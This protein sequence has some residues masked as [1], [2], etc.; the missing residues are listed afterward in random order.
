MIRAMRPLDAN[1]ARPLTSKSAANEL[2][3]P[4][5]PKTPPENRRLTLPRLI[6]SLLL[7]RRVAQRV[8]LAAEGATAHGIVVAR[9][10]ASGLIWD[11]EHLL[12]GDS[13]YACVELLHWVCHQARDAGARRVFLETPPDGPATDIARRSGFEQC[14]TGTVYELAAGFEIDSKD[15]FPARPR[16]RSDEASLFQLY[17]AVVPAPVRAAEA[18][19]YEEWAAL[20]RGGKLWQP[21]IV[22]HPEDYVW[23][24]GSRAVGWMHIIFG[25]RA[26]YL[27][28]LIHPQSEAFAERMV[29]DA[30]AQLSAK[31]PVLADVRE[32]QGM[33]QVALERVGFQR[34]HDY[35]VWVQQLA[36]RV[37]EPAVQA[38]RAQATPSG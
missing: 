29:R 16:L 35:L 14:T 3:A 10:R 32:Y 33:V 22:H 7:P 27:T 34:S 5:W 28:L 11:V 13:S 9:A 30:L 25:D 20:H 18:L 36:E 23:E 31:V 15:T 17:N 26:Q 4:N 37:A 6:S 1:A 24:M 38:V 21:S 19:T 2:T 12:S 8:G